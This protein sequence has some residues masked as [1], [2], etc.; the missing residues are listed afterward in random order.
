MSNTFAPLG[1]R[2]NLLTLQ[3]ALR[4]LTNDYNG[5]KRQV[6]GFPLLLQEA[7]RSVKAEVSKPTVEARHFYS[8]PL[9]ALLPKAHPTH[10]HTL[11]S[12]ELPSVPQYLIS[13]RVVCL[14]ETGLLAQADLDSVFSCLS[15][16]CNY[17]HLPRDMLGIEPRASHLVGKCS[18]TKL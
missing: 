4:T 10:I 16:S 5:L 18:P 8:E 3:P 7:L 17:W 13:T 15:L 6:R 1:V 14:F 11:S 9:L 2:T 12:H